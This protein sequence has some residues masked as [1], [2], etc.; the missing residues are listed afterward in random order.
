M[1]KNY[2]CQVEHNGK[3]SE[4]II[5]ESGVKQGCLPTHAYFIFNGIRYYDDKSDEQDGDHMISWKTWIL[6]M[7]SAFWH[8]VLKTWKQS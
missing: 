2:T 5:V 8:K 4:P 3:F 7:I 1:Y 6:L